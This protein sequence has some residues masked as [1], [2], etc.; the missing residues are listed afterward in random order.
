[1]AN[2]GR[3]T[4]QRRPAT[5]CS[6]VG[7]S[8]TDAPAL[9][10]QEVA[11]RRCTSLPCPCLKDH[12]E[13]KNWLKTTSN[14][15]CLSLLQRQPTAAPITGGKVTLTHLPG[16][17]LGEVV[18]AVMADCNVL[19][20]LEEPWYQIIHLGDLTILG[21]VVTRHCSITGD[22]SK[23]Y[24]EVTQRPY[25]GLFQTSTSSIYLSIYLVFSSKPVQIYD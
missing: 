15:D 14:Q 13:D 2:Y 10:G 8:D 7:E 12:I 25:Q 24:E 17:G 22:P 9:R 21:R 3:K 1:M 4:L 6:C 5:C 18:L 19:L 20:Y 23:K 16:D 11:D